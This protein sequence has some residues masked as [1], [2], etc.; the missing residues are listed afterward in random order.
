M[1]RI[2][3]AFLSLAYVLASETVAFKFDGGTVAFPT[4]D[5]VENSDG[6]IRWTVMNLS[7]S[8]VFFK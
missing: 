1:C 5:G 2:W 8:I 3:I 7:Y 6:L 4:L